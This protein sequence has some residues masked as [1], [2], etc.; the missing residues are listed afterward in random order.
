MAGER[1]LAGKRERGRIPRKDS[2]VISALDSSVILDVLTEDPRFGDSSEVLLR[3]ALNEG[4]L[5]IGECV[6]A[7]IAPALP[8]D[9][10]L[11]E[12]LADW[13]IGFVPSSRESAM[14][15][16]RSFAHYLSRG[17]RGG[18]VVADF[19]I[20]AHASIHADRLVAR[21]RGYLRD[22]FSGLPLLS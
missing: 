19:L 22:Y 8:N 5:L 18:R 20:G 14:L 4:S 3:R 7:E 11:L 12:F 16:G 1:Q 21:D 13:Q 9:E 10:L 17:G 2:K 6:L 15:A